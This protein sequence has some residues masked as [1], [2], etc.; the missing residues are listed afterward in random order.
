MQIRGYFLAKKGGEKQ[1]ET[2]VELK[3]CI[4]KKKMGKF[5]GTFTTLIY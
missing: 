4:L 1:L 2:S 3:K 5:L